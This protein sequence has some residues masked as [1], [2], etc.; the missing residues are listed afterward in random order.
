[1]TTLLSCSDDGEKTV[2]TGEDHQA[3]RFDIIHP[4]AT[5]RISETDFTQGDRIGVFINKVGTPLEPSGNEINNEALTYDDTW[6]AARQLYLDK[7]SYNVYAYYPYT[8]VTSVES[9]DVE[10][11]KDQTSSDN[12]SNSD[13]LYASNIGYS[14]FSSP[15]KLKFGH[16]MSKVLI[17]LIKS[18]DYEWELPKDA[19]VYIHNTVTQA[20][21]DLN[22]GY[23]TKKSKVMAK[24]IQVR[25][26]SDYIFEAIVVPQRIDTR[27]PLIEIV[28]NNI[29]YMFESKFVFK[30]GI[31]H[32]IDIVIP[33]SPDQIKM[34]IGGTTENWDNTTR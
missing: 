16:I 32:T 31:Q 26:S 19:K 11:L 24:T 20:T 27:T 22:T 14:D 34:D 17:R 3:L 25:Q 29:S 12:F 10:V 13:I 23:A 30:R 9:M 28:M 5:S 33:N 6:Q 15:I 4:Y 7:G 1:M 2:Q 18:E 8:N 21:L